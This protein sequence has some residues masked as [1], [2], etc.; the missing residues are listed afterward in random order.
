MKNKTPFHPTRIIRRIS[1][2][3]TRQNAWKHR[4][5]VGRGTYG[6]PRIR[7]SNGA[8]L[9]VGNFCSI[10]DNVTIFLGG[11]HRVDWISTYPFNVLWKSA[12]HIAGHPASKGDVVIG[13]DVW[14]G[15]GAVILSGI[16]IGSGS[17]IGAST[18]VS[19]DVPPYSIVVGNPG[20]VVKTR[21]KYDEILTLLN[22]EWWNWTDTK[23]DAGMDHILSG[24]ISNLQ[25]FS[26][27]YD[28]HNGNTLSTKGAKSS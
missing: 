15:E 21:F 1:A 16:T 6:S 26:E 17:V 10:A 25:E 9:K 13:H 4:Y 12:S 7:W 24:S 18:I 2:F 23:I 27:T 28:T 3:L 22:L 14:V 19:K 20:R 11:N 8:T 5:R